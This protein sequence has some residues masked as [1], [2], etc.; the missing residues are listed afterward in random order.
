LAVSQQR[1][2]EV[3]RYLEERLLERDQVLESVLESSA[4]AGLPPIAV[5]PN[6]GKLL[7]LLVQAI[8]ARSVLEIGT[9]GGYSTTWMA[10]ALPSDGR[11][12]SLEVDPGHAAVARS[13]LERAGLL[14]KVEI[15]LGPALDSMAQL[16]QEEG[17]GT[18]D[19][20]FIDADK[21]GTRRY[22]EESISLAR[23]GALIFV[24]N[25]VRDGQLI[26]EN[27]PDTRVQGMRAFVEYVATETRVQVT[28]L[29]TVGSKGYDGF[30]LA[31][32]N[33]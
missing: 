2:D 4:A 17:A 12:V 16:A 25:L 22:F 28:A 19:F 14:K 9:L 33:R 26:E 23:P 20:V 6:Q 15:R 24:D 30:A 21:E 7:A 11:L 1:W 29:Q 31:L 32:V 8:G 27:S 5:A 3:D 10:R 18:F 13:N